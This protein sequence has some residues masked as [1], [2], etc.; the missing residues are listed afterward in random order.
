MRQFLA[1]IVLL[2]AWAA[3]PPAGA[4]DGPLR[5]GVLNQQ[6]PIR[7]AERWNPIFAYLREVTGYEF[8]LRMGPRVEDTNAMMARG[9]FDLVFTNHNFRPEY[10]GVYRVIARWA[11]DPAHGVIAVLADSAVESLADLRGR[12]VAFPSRSALV[13]Y[14]ATRAELRRRKVAVEEVFAA[15][16][17]GALA[18]LKLRQ[19]EAASVN[20]RFLSDFVAREGVRVRTVFV[21]EPFADL[22]VLVHPRLDA[23]RVQAIRAALLAMRDDPRAAA[24]RGAAGF[25][26]FVAAGEGDYANARRAYRETA[27]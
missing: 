22:P 14:A 6:S 18:Q 1:T 2:A 16:Q 17:D 21:S 24:A 3:A 5:F 26:G 15:N 19:V 7:T 23:K 20:S 12:R 27:D 4:A 25:D 10:D 11:G 8:Q 9:E 13:A